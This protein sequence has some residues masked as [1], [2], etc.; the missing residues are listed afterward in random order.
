[1]LFISEAFAIYKARKTTKNRQS[2]FTLGLVG[3]IIV[4]YSS[5]ILNYWYHKILTLTPTTHR[6][7]IFCKILLHFV[8]VLNCGQILRICFF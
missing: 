5:N 8:L 7:K 1:M 3:L 2:E 4:I 6:K